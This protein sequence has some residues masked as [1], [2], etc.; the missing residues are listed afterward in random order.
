MD[1]YYSDDEECNAK[2]L[3][4]VHYLRQLIRTKNSVAYEI[5]A[6]EKPKPKHRQCP[7]QDRAYQGTIALR[8][9]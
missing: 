6:E 7:R 1:T 9:Q 4:N 3:Q 2:D 8:Q 5:T